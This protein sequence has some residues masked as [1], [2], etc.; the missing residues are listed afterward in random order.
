[1]KTQL[2]NSIQVG[3]VFSFILIF[4]IAIGFTVTMSDII[5]NL[6]NVSSSA[7]AGNMTGLLILFVLFGLWASS[8]AIGEN[9]SD[10]KTAVYCHQGLEWI[11]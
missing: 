8:K 2:K 4:F 1:M 3:L 10:W 7:R 9:R 6:I 11:I 5:G